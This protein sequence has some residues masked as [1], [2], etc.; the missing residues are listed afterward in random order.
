MAKIKDE[1]SNWVSF[2]CTGCKVRHAI[3]VKPDEKGWD[4]NGDI[5]NPTITPS[6]LVN[7]SQ[8]R[9]GVPLCHSFITDGNI[10]FLNDC[11]HE[12]SGQTIP[13]EEI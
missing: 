12:L 10:Q 11:T 8:L 6:I 2:Y 7:K 1:G 5:D 9:P 4:F 3:P 13:L